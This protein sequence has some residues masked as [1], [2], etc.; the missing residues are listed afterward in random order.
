MIENT[1]TP[2]QEIAKAKQDL[3]VS[4]ICDHITKMR[5]LSLTA[6]KDPNQGVKLALYAAPFFREH[7]IRIQKLLKGEEN[8]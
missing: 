5:M 3:E 2:D 4:V 8:A 1:K 7:G 6:D